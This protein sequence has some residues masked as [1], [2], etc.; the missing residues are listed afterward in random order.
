[1]RLV[2]RVIAFIAALLLPAALSSAALTDPGTAPEPVS[3]A[4]QLLVAAPGMGDPR[5][6]HAVILMVRHDRNGALGIIINRPV[7]EHAIADLLHGL[8]GQATPVEGRVRI[9]AGGPVEPDIGFV[10]H[11]AEY[12]RAETIEIDGSVSVTSS[13]AVLR[14]IALKHGPNKSLVAF[15]YAGWGPGQLEGEL[16]AKAWFTIAADAKL[17]FDEAREK[18]WDEALGRRGRDL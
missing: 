9:F 14:D 6:D 2:H 10:I 16:A 7:A 5:F 15:G 18:L 12:H 11:S 17:V 13:V 3:L 8:G 4:G 1:M